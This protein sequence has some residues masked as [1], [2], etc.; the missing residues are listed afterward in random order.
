M[1]ANTAI[2]GE[3]HNKIAEPVPSAARNLP[4]SMLGIAHGFS[5]P[6]APSLLRLRLRLA[7]AN[8]PRNDIM[9]TFLV[10]ASET[11]QSQGIADSP[12][13]ANANGVL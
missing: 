7:T 13:I 8:A 10:I 2:P 3:K 9:R 12:G 4:W 6:A 5:Q 11:K 1:G